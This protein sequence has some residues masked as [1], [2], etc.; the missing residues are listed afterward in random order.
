MFPLDYILQTVHCPLVRLELQCSH[1]STRACLYFTDL[2]VEALAESV[3]LIERQVLEFRTIFEFSKIDVLNV[4][5]CDLCKLGEA[6]LEIVREVLYPL[7]LKL[8]KLV[9][10]S[11]HVRSLFFRRSEGGHSMQSAEFAGWID[12]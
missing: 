2:L 5:V 6:A 10:S 7:A 9:G 11:W 4:F 12:G 1:L 3:E 8:D